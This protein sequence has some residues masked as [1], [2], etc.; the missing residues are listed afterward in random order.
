MKWRRVMTTLGS[1]VDDLLLLAGLGAITWG[2]RMVYEPAAYVVGGLSLC[3]LA[4][5]VSR[6]KR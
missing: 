3:G 6:A 2:V 5:V 4:F 1:F